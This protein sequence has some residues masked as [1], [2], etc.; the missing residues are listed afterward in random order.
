MPGDLRGRL[1][2]ITGGARNVGAVLSRTFAAHGAHVLVNYFHAHDEAVRLA[3]E[4][5]QAGSEV[6][7]LRASV[8]RPEHVDAMFAEIRSRFGRLDV[9]VNN[10]ADG[11]LRLMGDVTEEDVQRALDV[12]YKGALRCSRA[13]AELMAA[14]GGGSIVMV[15]A[16]GSSQLVMRGYGA[17]APA[18]SAMETVARY[19]AVE[20]APRGIRVNTASAAML[21]SDVAGRFPDAE[22]LQRT[23][24]GAT[25]LGRLGEPHELAEVV[26]FLAS[27]RASWMTGQVVLADGGLSLGAALLSPSR[28]RGAT[29]GS[30][31]IEEETPED[32]AEDL[33]VVVG[34]GLIVSGADSPEKFWDL[35][36]SGAELFRPAPD[37]RWRRMMFRSDVA[38]AEDKS[39]QDVSVFIDTA[40][41]PSGEEHTT[42]WLRHSFAQALDGVTLTGSDRCSLTI[43]Y[44]P[45][46]NQH[47]EEAGVI[48]GTHRLLADVLAEMGRSP[49]DRDALLADAGRRLREHYPRGAAAAGAFLPHRIGAR[50]LL[51]RLPPDAELQMVDTAC[52][53]SLYAVDIGAK[54]LRSGRHDVAV[55]GGA[56]ALG[57]RGTV[58]F[59][60]LQGLSGRGDI[61][62]LD[63]AADGVLFA[64]GAAVVVLKLRSRAVR[65]GDQILGVLGSFGASSD[66]KG[67]SIYAPNANGQDL[68]V[69]RALETR[70]LGPAEV[71]WVNAHATG[72][73]AGDAAEFTTL[74]RHYGGRRTL[75]TSNKSL[76]G[77]TGWAAGAVSLIES[78][79]A[80][81]AATIPAQKRFRAAPAHFAMETH[82]LVIP[83]RPQPWPAVP[84]R[85]R[86]AAVS[87]FGFGGTNAHLLLHGPE[88]ALA[89]SPRPPVPDTSRLAIVAWS[90]DFPGLASPDE[91]REWLGD[92]RRPARSF[93]PTYPIPSFDRVRL[94]PATLRN[95]DRCQLMALA[96]AHG[97]RDRLGDFWTARTAS[98]AVVTAHLGPSRAAMAAAYRCYL[99]D[100]EEA[101][102]G[103][104]VPDA[105]TNAEIRKRFHARVH[106]EVP[107]TSPDSFPGMMPNIVAAR[108]ANFFDLHGPNIAV[109]AGLASTC[110]A[111]DIAGRYLSTGEAALALVG[112]FNGNSLPEF[113]AILGDA[114]LPAPAEGA[115][116]FA[117]VREADV[118]ETG[119]PVL[120]YVGSRH[121]GEPDPASPVPRADLGDDEAYLGGAGAVAILRALHGG[122]GPV[123]LVSGGRQGVPSEYL[124]LDVTGETT[125]GRA[126][127]ARVARHVAT[128]VP[129]ASA[130]VRQAVPFLPSGAVV[131]TDVPE[132]LTAPGIP[133]EQLAVLSTAPLPAG[134]PTAW[135]HVEDVTAEA[136]DAALAGSTGR[137][138]RMLTDLDRPGS[139][140]TLLQDL[141][142]LAVR[143]CQPAL[144][145]PG[146]SMVSLVLNGFRGGVPHPD[147]GI[148]TGFT[149]AAALELRDAMVLA[150]LTADGSLT[151]G[152]GAAEQETALHHDLP[153][154]YVDTATAIR[155]MY[156][157]VPRE[158]RRPLDGTM[159]LSRDSVVVALGGARGITAETVKAL[160]AEYLPFIC[161]LGSTDLGTTDPDSDVA[162]PAGCGRADFL[163]RHMADGRSVAEL[164]REFGHLVR[165]RE[166]R[167]NVDEITKLC[168][169]GR[170]VYLRCDAR[171]PGELRRAIDEVETRFGPIDLLI[172]A[173]GV[174]RSGRIEQ[175]TLAEFRA[176]RDLKVS[177]YQN[178]ERA[179]H[180]REPRLWCNF[181]SLL[182]FF[183]QVG[184]SDYAAANDFLATAAA[185]A[186][187]RG[188]TETTIG[189]T[190][191]DGAGMAS[192]PLVDAY[193]RR[194]GD[195]THM[196]VAEGV[197][198]FLDE[199]RSGLDEPLVVHLGRAEHA[200]VRRHYPGLR[201]SRG[202]HYLRSQ[203]T[204]GRDQQFHDC[205][206]SPDRDAYLS[207]HLVGGVATMPGMFLVEMAAEAAR[208]IT[209]GHGV[210]IAV[211][212]LTF[213]H[214]VR[215]RLNATAPPLKLITRV[216]E[217]SRVEVRVCTD[218][219]A[220][221]GQVLVRGRILCACTVLMAE[222]YPSA[223][224]WASAVLLD[225]RPVPDPY[226]Q[227]GSPVRLSGPFSCLRS[228]RLHA[229]GA[230]STF[231]FAGQP[232]PGFLT[233]VVL[234]DAMA[235]TA[236][237]NLTPDGEARVPVP[238]GVRR[239]DLYQ[240]ASDEELARKHGSLRIFATPA[241]SLS[242]GDRVVAVDE[243]DRVVAQI[244]G[245]HAKIMGTVRAGVPA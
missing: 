62:A 57:P 237:F 147:A 141:H 89:R 63:E 45:D 61:R 19:L 112:G 106:E 108:V 188:R 245:I 75:V 41:A 164:N 201:D 37:D 193:Y 122:P 23:I 222:E 102:A 175:K 29:A 33:V 14:S 40:N 206:L 198:H 216:L 196:T 103:I 84:G 219:V 82:N 240:E 58:L 135:H 38:D 217:P 70:K 20:Y 228:T 227:P 50:V 34:M 151:A 183:G 184:E 32:E 208:D 3:Q 121:R 172:N 136:V 105:V 233:P 210:P 221:S 111:L 21:R 104:A 230:C 163:R 7:L 236:A 191:W 22:S 117:V 182:G 36:M 64:D 118:R 43:G 189:W 35:T 119:L 71:Q 178:L 244:K 220:P 93:G 16:L 27:D 107:A 194:A 148:V 199:V 202:R 187:A 134:A 110:A 74:R 123:H 149:K 99:D 232:A 126:P 150:V 114:G 100:L 214:F 125:G 192:E 155:R 51:D 156:T 146:A 90:A 67:R 211:E 96:C 145:D 86:V 200:T 98:T 116:M 203:P 186:R 243:A 97:L 223:P 138:L 235:R 15:S 132:R 130:T 42:A 143:R 242:P 174:S 180:G 47:L 144:S 68:A 113:A 162:E 17:C 46:G 8:A 120:A 131:V 78:L 173:A 171:E 158:G 205:P 44:T 129:A 161:L 154:V 92:R 65:D 179:L 66:G 9:L 185:F 59:A 1:A 169:P 83:T 79:L 204:A 60:K 140:V 152:S 77:H 127:E 95:V 226:R 5:R 109:D 238:L 166:A 209:A 190:L 24:A 11:A 94:P 167:R 165:V 76:V 225:E 72:T 231:V 80:L 2:L 124:R 128:L 160:A 12:D 18:K 168:G 28:E 39:Y 6:D 25:P 56:F 115:V 137:H 52:S 241:D 207:H 170:V 218:V 13:A 85:T 49:G 181:G 30:D 53:S 91:V 101:L 133:A 153:A 224:G 88:R 229:D 73:P 87:S 142:Y 234:L 157:V 69:G 197:R 48:L 139:N 4:L 239:V 215:L 159:V 177:V 195:Y 213:H 10:A 55:C 212:D 54:G 31:A 176:V 26:A 81:R